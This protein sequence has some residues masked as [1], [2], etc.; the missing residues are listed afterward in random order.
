M[1]LRQEKICKQIKNH[2]KQYIIK[3]IH[4]LYLAKPNNFTHTFHA[5]SYDLPSVSLQ[6]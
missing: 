2:I 5:L 6:G 1:Y 3:K 4:I